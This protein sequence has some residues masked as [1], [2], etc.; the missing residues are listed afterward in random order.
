MRNDVQL[1]GVV[2]GVLLLILCVIGLRSA[3][4]VLGAV[5]P[6]LL[7]VSVT[8]A[9]AA[10]ASPIHGINLGFAAALLGLSLDYWIHLYVEAS[11]HGTAQ[12]FAERL[13]IARRALRHILPALA[14]S[15]TS[16]AG[17]FAVLTFSRYP[18]VQTLGITGA[19]AASSAF[20]AV[21][22]I[23]PSAVALAGTRALPAPPR[24]PPRLLSWLRPVLLA[25]S[26]VAALYAMSASFDGD[27]QKLLSPADAIV[28]AEQDLTSR[29]GGFGTRGIVA[30]RPRRRCS[31]GR[32]RR[33][34]ARTGADPGRP[35]WSAS[36]RCS[37]DPSS[38]PGGRRRFQGSTSCSG[39]SIVRRRRAGFVEGALDGEAARIHARAGQV[40]RD[41]WEGTPL[42]RPG[43]A[44][45]RR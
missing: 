17:A 41:A 44:P 14:V 19:A 12:T 9:A 40:P 27:P 39:A 2:G 38:E 13:Q 35:R 15:A 3:R 4:P 18:V 33:C 7:V 31:H 29:Y 23:G 37:P 5:L 8:A 36:V 30:L 34:A 32:G 6:L 22:L 21:W 16:T 43:A 42:A 26:A 24:V 25:G 28:Q 20:A 1:S 10:L 45:H 11:R